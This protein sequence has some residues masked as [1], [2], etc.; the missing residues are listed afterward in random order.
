MK[1][2]HAVK[3]PSRISGMLFI[4]F[5]KRSREQCAKNPRELA[6]FLIPS[7]SRLV[8]KIYYFVLYL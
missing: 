3:P 8:K 4:L 7:F 1:I 2:G 5:E 6:L